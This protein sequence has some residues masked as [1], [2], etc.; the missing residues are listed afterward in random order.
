MRAS[1]ILLLVVLT[2]AAIMLNHFSYGVR[3]LAYCKAEDV[4]YGMAQW[5]PME[6]SK[7]RRASCARPVARS[8]RKKIQ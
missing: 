2:V 5:L 8:G 6:A 1:K 7:V 4:G 3:H